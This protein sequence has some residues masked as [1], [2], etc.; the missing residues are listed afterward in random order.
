M[1][2]NLCDGTAVGQNIFLA[3]WDEEEPVESVKEAVSQAVDA[4]YSQVISPGLIP[5][6]VNP[7]M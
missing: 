1:I 5:E 6:D 7:Y 3:S 2:R 4:W